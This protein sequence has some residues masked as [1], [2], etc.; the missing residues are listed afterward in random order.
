MSTTVMHK[1]LNF[2]NES[3]IEPT[4][5]HSCE[6]LLTLAATNNFLCKLFNTKGEKSIQKQIKPFQINPSYISF[7]LMIGSGLIY[8]Q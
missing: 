2:L 3:V 1:K 6:V 8:K 4:K 5:E 7:H